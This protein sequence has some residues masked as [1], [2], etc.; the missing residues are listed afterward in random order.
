MRTAS[1]VTRCPARCRATSRR[2]RDTWS[3]RPGNTPV[4]AVAA[5][6]A[7]LTWLSLAVW[8]PPARNMGWPGV[9]HPVPAP[10]RQD[11][12]GTGVCTRCQGCWPVR[13][14]SSASM[15]LRCA[16]IGTRAGESCLASA[17]LAWSSRLVRSSSRD[18]SRL[19]SCGRPGSGIGD[20][21]AVCLLG[22]HAVEGGLQVSL[23]GGNGVLAA[24][25]LDGALKLAAVVLQLVRCQCVQGVLGLIC[26]WVCCE[27][28]VAGIGWRS[29]YGMAGVISLPNV[30]ARARN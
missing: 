11:G 7:A 9:A 6:A 16:W 10:A 18:V 2:A 17:R 30:A 23:H 1:S 19:T 13:C 15:A 14:A 24:G 5:W 20:P 12:G 26:C 8:P 22:Y 28:A 3:A 21:L 29:S 4:Y 27:A 25:E